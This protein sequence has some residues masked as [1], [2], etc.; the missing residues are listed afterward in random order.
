MSTFVLV[1]GSWHGS[2]CWY[3]V[4]PLLENAGHKVFTIDLPGPDKDLHKAKDITMQDFVDSV[5]KVIDEIQEQVI[6]VGHSRG[7]IVISEVA[8]QRPDKIK[9]L[10]YLTAFLIPP[11]QAMITTALADSNSLIGPNLIISEEEGW[12]MIKNEFIKEAFYADCSEEDIK[13]AVAHLRP[14]PNAPLATPLKLTEQ[15]FGRIPRVYIKCLLDKGIS[16][17]IQE[18]MYTKMP[19]EKV[20]SINASH[21]PFLSMP[22]ELVS[23]LVSV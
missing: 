18:Q 1:H 9:K 8:E 3:K 15:N 22:E 14:E 12:H 6:L 2:W 16:P 21:S 7:G 4:V 19:C 13:M 11:N 17:A 5:T 20:I 10:I 23:H